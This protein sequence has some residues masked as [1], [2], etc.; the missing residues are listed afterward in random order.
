VNS[1]RI[2]WRVLTYRPTL[3]NYLGAS[4]HWA[5]IHSLPIWVGLIVRAFLDQLAP[6][7]ELGPNL[8]LLLVLYVALGGFS[9]IILSGT[10]IALG[11]PWPDASFSVVTQSLLRR[12][13][14]A[15]LV[16]GPGAPRLPGTPAEALS[17]LRDDTAE[18]EGYV[19]WYGDLWGMLIYVGVGMTVML[20]IS[21]TITLVVVLPMLGVVV[22][23]NRLGPRLRVYRQ[24]ERESAGR[25]SELLGGLFAGVP[26]V[27]VASA[28]ARATA[29][30]SRLND[31]RRRAALRDRLFSEL[32]DVVSRNL[33]LVATGVV[34]LLAADAMQAGTFTVGDFALFAIYMPRM[35]EL[36]LSF[37]GISARHARLP[38]STDRL[39]ALADGMPR[40]RLVEH[41]PIHAEGAP[42][43]VPELV[44]RPS[45]RLEQLEV[46]DLSSGAIGGVGFVLRRGT[47][48]VVAG[49]VGAGKTTLLRALLGLLA[50]R[51]GAIL[52]NGQPVDDPGTLMVPPR[53]AYVPQV[54]RLFSETL[55]ENVV[56]GQPWD[57]ARLAEALRLAVL[58]QDVATF[59]KGYDT[60]VGPRGVKLSGGQVQR[61]AAARALIAEPEL[62]VVDDL[63]SALDVET[64][65][66]LWRGL[67]GRTVLAVSNRPAAWRAADQ[68]VVLS[69][70]R[71]EASGPLDVLLRESAEM[72]ALW[73]AA[74]ERDDPPARRA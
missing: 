55:R 72:Q 58:E 42:P 5:C 46:V 57:G 10:W 6:G 45:D 38:V 31:A 27:Q 1:W 26:A 68:V 32:L 54:P 65:R 70:G 69:G 21:P 39:V 34:L 67:A 74:D 41:A 12:N 22:A 24:R 15:W 64:E 11:I 56:M 53:V 13:V 2:L 18:V 71:V 66:S 19:G 9:G 25:V 23:A 50:R 16:A 63:S 73:S 62:L 4:L 49:R 14:L 48:T 40:D 37:S 3:R 7:V 29:R 59:E 33:A 35:G 36:V 61:A 43:A 60:L 51:S 44:K 47:L 30:L 8:W 28:E 20:A 17:R 52:W